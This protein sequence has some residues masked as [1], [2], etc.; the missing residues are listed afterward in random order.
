MATGGYALQQSGTLSHRASRLMWLRSSIGV[1]ARLVVLIGSPIDE[2]GM[3][4]IDKNSPLRHGKMTRPFLDD[5]VFINV[6]FMF[7][8]AVSVSASIHRIRQNVMDRGISRSDPADR[9]GP[10]G[11]I[12]LQGEGQLLRS[13][14]EPDAARRAEFVKAFKDGADRAD[15][16]L[17][18]M[19]Q[20]FT[21]LLSP[22]KPN[23]QTAAQFAARRF[24]TNT[25]V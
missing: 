8:L 6:T 20:N 15:D 24:V 21:I 22:N 16:C 3:M 7:G 18:W 5:T 4:A 10:A 12:L 1:K 25:A 17:V 11:G 9:T 13:E 14:Q 19:K 23:R 2:T